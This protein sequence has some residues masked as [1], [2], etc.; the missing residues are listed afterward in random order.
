MFLL[1]LQILADPGRFTTAKFKR[2]Y[3]ILSNV[4]TFMAKD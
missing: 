3:A 4:G 1:V 2:K